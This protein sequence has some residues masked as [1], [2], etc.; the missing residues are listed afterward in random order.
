MCKGETQVCR[1]SVDTAAASSAPPGS[2]GIAL[3][4]CTTCARIALQEQRHMSSR[5]QLNLHPA[6]NDAVPTLSQIDNP[7]PST[8]P[9]HHSPSLEEGDVRHWVLGGVVQKLLRQATSHTGTG[10]ARSRALGAAVA[11]AVA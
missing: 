6:R 10:A 5:D 9:H 11:A 4:G 1:P 8:H 7:M 3:S 2:P